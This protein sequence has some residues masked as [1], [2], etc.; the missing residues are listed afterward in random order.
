MPPSS[1]LSVVSRLTDVLIPVVNTVASFAPI[2][3]EPLGNRVAAD[4]VFRFD[5]Q[6]HS[7]EMERL[8]HFPKR[9][10]L[11]LQRLAD[12]GFDAPEQRSQRSLASVSRETTLRTLLG[13]IKASIGEALEH[14]HLPF[15]KMV[16][17]PDGAAPPF[18]EKAGADAPAPRR[19][20][21]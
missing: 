18:S 16:Y 9:Q 20:R 3:P 4:T 2:H 8:H 7:I 5:R 21:L 14:Q 15:R 19:W 10:V 1:V 13:G 12:G 11:M 17:S 6:N